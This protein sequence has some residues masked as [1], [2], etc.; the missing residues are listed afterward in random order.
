MCAYVCVPIITKEIVMN[1]R[2]MDTG[3]GGGGGN[4]VHTVFMH[5]I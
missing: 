3:G 5:E 1:S 2:Q 4:D